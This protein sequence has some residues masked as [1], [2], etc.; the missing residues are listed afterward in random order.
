MTLFNGQL[1]RD[2]T[3]GISNPRRAFVSVNDT[4][5]WFIFQNTQI[6]SSKWTRVWESD[7]VSGPANDG[8]NTQR[9]VNVAACSVRGANTTTAQSWGLYQASDGCQILIA[10]T[11]ASDD[12]IRITYSPGGL[13]TRAGTATFPPTASDE[14]FITQSTT[15]VNGTASLDRALY[16]ACVDK[17]WRCAVF[18]GGGTIRILMLQEATSL[19]INGIFGLGTVGY[20]SYVG[21]AHTNANRSGGTGTSWTSPP[22]STAIGGANFNGAVCRVFTNAAARNIKLGAGEIT[23]SQTGNVLNN[24]QQAYIGSPTATPAAQGGKIPL[25]PIIWSGEPVANVDGYWASPIDWWIAM[26]TTSTPSLGDFTPG[27]DPT[28]VPGVS[29]GQTGVGDPRTNW[30]LALGPNCIWPWRNFQA[31]LDTGV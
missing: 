30:L 9:L 16:I 19:S 5:G 13:Y 15:V 14:N 17:D 25:L 11:G 7:G 20:P 12:V 27:F 6:L 26:L 28:D 29:G 18:R 3:G 24:Q 4:A 23:H 2:W 10:Y 1:T 21:G 8:D 31:A 22:L